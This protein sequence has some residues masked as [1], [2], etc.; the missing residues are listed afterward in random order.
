MPFASATYPHAACSNLNNLRELQ[1]GMQATDKLRAGEDEFTTS[2]NGFGTG[3]KELF[4]NTVTER[5]N[6][7]A[8]RLAAIAQHAVYEPP[9]TAATL[10]NLANQARVRD[11]VAADLQPLN[12][13]PLASTHYAHPVHGDL[14]IVARDAG[15]NVA[16]FALRLRAPDGSTG[17]VHQSMSFHQDPHT[18][19]H[20]FGT[21]D[22]DLD[23]TKLTHRPEDDLRNKGLGTAL[24]RTAALAAQQSNA[25]LVVIESCVTDASQALCQSLGMQVGPNDYHSTPAQIIAASNGKL[26]AKGWVAQP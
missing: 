9:G 7:V 11:I 21:S 15:N 24:M 14:S 3:L 26:A 25:H 23:R 19:A 17:R 6:Q 20:T 10:T 13:P 12:P 5:R 2:T 22:I 8:D 4:F 16:Q 1:P 18:G